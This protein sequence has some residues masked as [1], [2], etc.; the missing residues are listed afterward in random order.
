[1]AAIEKS[2][3]LDLPPVLLTPLHW[4]EQDRPDFYKLHV[5]P[6]LARYEL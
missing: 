4:F 1:M 5:A 2:L 3:M 6:L